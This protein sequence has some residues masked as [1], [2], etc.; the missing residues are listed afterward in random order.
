MRDGFLLYLSQKGN[1]FAGRQVELLIEDDEAKPDVGLTK[2]KRL[3]ERDKVDLLCGIVH[4][5]V[6]LAIAEYVKGQKIP[7]M[8]HNAAA[9]ALTQQRFNQYIFRSSFSSSQLSHPLGEWAY[10]KG[11][12]KAAI[13]SS[14]YTAGWEYSGGFARTF[15]EKGGRIVQEIYLP[16][17]TPDPGPFITAIKT[18]V[19]M[20]YAF[21]AGADALRFVRR[22]D[23]Y[24]MKKRAVLFG[25]GPLTHDS[26]LPEEGDSA[27]GILCSNTYTTVLDNPA[28]KAF[29][30][31][32]LKKYNRPATSFTLL[33]YT[34][35]T[36]LEKALESIRGN[37]EDRGSFIKALEKVEI[38]DTP[39]GPVRFD[40]YHNIVVDNYMCEVK[41][42]DGELV[43]SVVD[44]QKDVSQFWKWSPEEYMKMPT[45][46]SLKGK[47]AK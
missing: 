39:R 45:Y 32:V 40:K 19:D 43:N 5:G 21:H 18:E 9:D 14:D 11:F 37:I 15:T 3:V 17:G 10:M 33:G 4:S 26:I 27:L 7:L 36:M 42:I 1:Q 34:G 13:V 8:I 16:L 44:T 2:A 35:G 20:V 28:N 24:G 30:N 12:R 6:A 46:S 23:E 38:L 47:W 41:K 25:A 22:F 31:A 29:K